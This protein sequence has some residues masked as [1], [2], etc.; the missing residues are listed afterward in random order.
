MA[1]LITGLCSKSKS[2][3]SI[4]MSPSPAVSASENMVSIKLLKNFSSAYERDG[5]PINSLKY[6][7]LVFMAYLVKDLVFVF[8][9]QCESIYENEIRKFSPP[10]CTNPLFCYSVAEEQNPGSG[11][12]EEPSNKPVRTC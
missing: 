2:S 1:T 6:D 9:S 12:V 10:S 3:V 5:S 8:L 11:N 4:S 7:L